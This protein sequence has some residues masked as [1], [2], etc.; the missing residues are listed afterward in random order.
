MNEFVLNLDQEIFLFINSFH[1]P[2]W[3]IVMKMA[4]GKL[5]WG[6]LYFSLLFSIWRMFGWRA[7]IL[8]SVMTAVAV[9]C[10]DQVSASLIRPMFERLRPSNPNNP[11]SEYVHIVNGYR[12]GRYGFPS[13]HAANTF[14][15]ATLMSFLF[16]R[17]RFSIFIFAWAVLNCYSRVYLG[18]HYPGDLLAGL[19]IGCISG[20]TFYIIG[21]FIA[22][23]LKINI[24][25]HRA[26][27]LSFNFTHAGSMICQPYDIA[28]WTGV[29]TMVFILLCASAL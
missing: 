1:S 6:L 27:T 24:R 13:C 11:L 15:V 25:P 9:S 21:G 2:Y 4:S 5:V 12:G 14:A 3:D 16:W 19:V 22:R 20:T 8:F 7:L 17:L 26:D 28:G 18:V 23:R 10:A 29:I